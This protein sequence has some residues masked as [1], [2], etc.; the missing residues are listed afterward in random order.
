MKIIPSLGLVTNQAPQK[1]YGEEEEAFPTPSVLKLWAQCVYQKQAHTHRQKGKAQRPSI[2]WEERRTHATPPTLPL[3]FW[4]REEF[5]CSLW[6]ACLGQNIYL[7]LHTRLHAHTGGTIFSPRK[8]ASLGKAYE[9]LPGQTR[10]DLTCTFCLF[11][12]PLP[13][14]HMHAI[15][16]SPLLFGVVTVGTDGRGGGQGGWQ[17]P[18]LSQKEKGQKG[19]HGHGQQK[20]KRT[21]FQEEER[22]FEHSQLN[23]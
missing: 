12:C 14:P 5:V 22:K 6:P 16:S 13:S 21:N 7:N 17:L 18:P 9:R 15:M 19:G 4:G 20:G 11:P 3:P 10:K 2:L 8:Q 23:I 1:L